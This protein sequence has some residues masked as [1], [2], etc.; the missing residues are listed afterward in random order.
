MTKVTRTLTAVGLSVAIPLGAL[1]APLVHAHPDDVDTDHHRAH[2]VHAHFTGHSTL[3]TF[4]DG[5]RF[6]DHEGER[7]VYLQLFVAVPQA[8]FDTPA[9]AVTCFDLG[10]PAESPARH[11]LRV[12]HG[13]DPPTLTSLPS[14]APPA[15]PS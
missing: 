9:A 15:F 10:A 14:R 4:P 11:S 3:S 5:A 6:D 2:E 7:A 1:C 8:S 12:V 13:H